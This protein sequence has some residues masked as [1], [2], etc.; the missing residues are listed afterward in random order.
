MGQNVTN[1]LVCS[2][3]YF[4]SPWH[5]TSCMQTF[6][7]ELFLQLTWWNV[8]NQLYPVTLKLQPA[9][10]CWLPDFPPAPNLTENISQ[11]RY[12]GLK[13]TLCWVLHKPLTVD[14][15]KSNML[16]SFVLFSPS[17][18]SSW[19]SGSDSRLDQSLWPLCFPLK[20]VGLSGEL[21]WLRL[22]YFAIKTSLFLNPA[23]KP[24]VGYRA[25]FSMWVVTSSHCFQLSNKANKLDKNR[26]TQT[27]L[28]K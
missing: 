12:G 17:I 18:V 22:I 25:F 24:F 27:S 8:D 19:W 10:T 13:L 3:L 26:K 4:K 1:M 5:E 21:S 23:S 9:R 14:E 20:M 7:L 6:V 16:C 11:G 28:N 2:L 15:S